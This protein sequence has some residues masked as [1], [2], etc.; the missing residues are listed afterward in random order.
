MKHRLGGAQY[1]SSAPC[2]RIS[3]RC[4]GHV[5][6]TC[7]GPVGQEA[8]INR[9]ARGGMPGN[10]P[11][12]SK[13]FVVRVCDNNEHSSAQLVVSLRHAETSSATRCDDAATRPRFSIDPEYAIGVPSSDVN[14]PPAVSSKRCAGAR[15]QSL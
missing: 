6:A 10:R 1:R 9:I 4:G 14:T 5:I 3:P 7:A 15:S 12:A 2:C 13:D 8:Y 11:P